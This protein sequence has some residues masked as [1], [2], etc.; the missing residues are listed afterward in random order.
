MALLSSWA[1]TRR[2]SWVVTS[3]REAPKV[4]PDWG[5]VSAQADSSQSELISAQFVADLNL[6][7]S[8]LS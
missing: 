5:E 4:V 2:N 7:S 3:T 6:I 1:W 8:K